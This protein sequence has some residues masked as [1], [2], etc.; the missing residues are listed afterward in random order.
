MFRRNVL[1]PSSE[2]KSKLSNKTVKIE[3]SEPC[4]AE[5][6]ELKYGHDLQGARTQALL[7]GRPASKYETTKFEVLTKVTLKSTAFWDLR[8][9]ISMMT[10]VSEEKVAYTIRVKE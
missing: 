7:L 3:R 9:R 4:E 10:D 8:P 2:S 1:L 6:N 5:E